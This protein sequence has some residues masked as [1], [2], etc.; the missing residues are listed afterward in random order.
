M[1][2][3]VHFCCFTILELFPDIHSEET[4]NIPFFQGEG[5]EPWN[6]QHEISCKLPPCFFAASSC[7]TMTTAPAARAQGE[8]GTLG[9]LSWAYSA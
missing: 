7:K 6:S 9:F 3:H 2:N 8:I 1:A 4:H 5:S